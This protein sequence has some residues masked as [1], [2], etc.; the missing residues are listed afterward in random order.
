MLRLLRSM[1]MLACD[2]VVF[3]HSSSVASPLN[4]FISRFC[5]EILILPIGRLVESLVHQFRG[6]VDLI[7]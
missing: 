3:L 1:C 7:E 2:I 6:W 5:A 4:L